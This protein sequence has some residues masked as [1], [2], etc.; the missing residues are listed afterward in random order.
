V[1][2]LRLS[3]GSRHGVV[4][5]TGQCA[6]ARANFAKGIMLLMLTACLSCGGAPSS[7]N[8]PE[9]PGG[10]IWR[11]DL[12]V[13]ANC[14]RQALLMADD[15]QWTG[16]KAFLPIIPLSRKLPWKCP[17]GFLNTVPQAA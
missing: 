3:S 10:R 1:L 11:L 9:E 6:A 2:S 15:L 4:R 8:P 5:S 17:Y 16:V 7:G 12:S 14:P 13:R